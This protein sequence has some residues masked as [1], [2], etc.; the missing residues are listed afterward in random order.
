[1]KSSLYSILFTLLIITT[2]INHSA[3]P[4]VFYFTTISIILVIFIVYIWDTSRIVFPQTPAILLF[5]IFSIY[6]YH[7]LDNP[8]VLDSISR[9][10]IFIIMT[11]ILIFIVPLV[12]DKARFLQITAITSAIFIFVSLP[13]MFIGEFSL[14]IFES[15]VR[16]KHPV[17]GLYRIE[18]IST[19]TVTSGYI[20][21]IGLI[22]SLSIR[23][24]IIRK[25]IFFICL[26]G[27]VLPHSRA[28]YAAALASIAVILM[29]RII[30]RENVIWW[31]YMFFML[32]M[33]L[34]L[35]A[36]KL[37]PS[38][39]FINIID[40]AGRDEIFQVG[41]R[42]F[43]ADPLLGHG[44]RNLTELVQQYTDR[45]SVG[46]G[47]YNQFLRM[48]ITT[49]IVGGM[50]Y[51][52]LILIGVL[53]FRVKHANSDELIIYALFIGIFVN[54]LFTGRTILGLS[55]SSVIGAITLGYLFQNIYYRPCNS[56]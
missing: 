38:P 15:T 21:S 23:I 49:G 40:S 20:A 1:M 10:L 22:S 47:V 46:A 44:P 42:T 39:D 36:M 13:S 37:I 8:L 52:I 30:G 48:F 28:A 33:I 27:V 41:I 18:S 50:S 5:V 4:F 3:V 35:S 43:F 17:I 31:I 51:L 29:I 12:V 11:P 25:M 54:E 19:T 55:H 6:L 16:G 34:F 9:V 2:I 24:S 26:L 56:T 45:Y 32:G 7:L 14:Y 53:R